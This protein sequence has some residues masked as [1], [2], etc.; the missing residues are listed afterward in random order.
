MKSQYERIVAWQEDV[1]KVHQAHKEK[2]IE[3]K[4][5]IDRV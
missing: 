2:I 5:F 4:E 1:Q 3:A